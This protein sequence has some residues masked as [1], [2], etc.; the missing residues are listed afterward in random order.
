MRLYLEAKSENGIGYTPDWVQ[1]SYTENGTVYELNLDV[2]GEIDYDKTCLSCH[3][4]GELIPWTLVNLDDGDEED[5]SELTNEELEARFPE[6]KL[7]EILRK[8]F[9]FLV[10]IYPVDDTNFK[11]DR[12]SKGNGSIE[13]YIEE[14]D[15]YCSINFEFDTEINI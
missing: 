8:G 2:R 14:E 12:V 7:V 10:G 11:D 9:E 5:L 4:K 3:C 6:K 13:L 1:V 15:K